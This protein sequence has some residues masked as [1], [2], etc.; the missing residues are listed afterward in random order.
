MKKYQEI[1][2]ISRSE[3]QRIFVQGGP[4]EI[5]L[6]LVRL[7]YHDPD[8]MWVQDI[9]ISLSTH[10]DKWIRQT[11]VICFSHI[12]RIHGKLE[13]QKVMPVLNRLLHDPEVKGEV[14]VT[15]DGLEIFLKE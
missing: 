11:C 7:A 15:I 2:P 12:A 6:T 4:D 14:E 3:A 10:H 5:S 1:T 13:R 9:C 8:W